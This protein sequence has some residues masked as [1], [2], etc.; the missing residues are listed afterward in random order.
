MDE[1]FAV[2]VK[3]LSHL[4]ILLAVHTYIQTGGEV[5]IVVRF[6]ILTAASMKM[7]AFWEIAPSSFVEVNQSLLP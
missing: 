4:K 5:L 7:R 2:Y 1:E 3:K 6:H